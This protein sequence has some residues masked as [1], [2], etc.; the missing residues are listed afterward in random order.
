[1]NNHWVSG[2]CIILLVVLPAW[3]RCHIKIGGFG[4][5]NQGETRWFLGQ[6]GWVGWKKRYQRFMCIYVF[7]EIYKCLIDCLI[8]CLFDWLIDWLI[9]CLIVC[10]FVCFEKMAIIL[11]LIYLD[12]YKRGD[13]SMQQ[14]LHR[15]LDWSWHISQRLSLVPPN[16]RCPNTDVSLFKHIKQQ[17]YGSW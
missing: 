14:F 5:T 10:L 1:M 2:C 8:D 9:D 12:P 4:F 7:F 16:N 11:N 3:R 17:I 15:S 13:W 6:S